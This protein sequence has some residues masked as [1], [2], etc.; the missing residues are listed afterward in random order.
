MS[1]QVNE[2]G[3]NVES[4]AL[5]AEALLREHPDAL[6]CGLS[7]DG[8]IVPVPQSVGLWGQE[9]IEGRAVV[10]AVVAADRKTVI[11][12][13]LRAR[14]EGVAEGKVRLLAKPSRWMTLHFLDLR[15]VH[16]VVLCILLPSDEVAEGEDSQANELP[17]A[18][19]RF[20]TLM[21]DESGVVLDCDEAFM[22]MF[23]YTAE[24]VIGKQVL[25]QLHPDDHARAVEG[26]IAML[27]SRRVQQFRCRRKRKDGSWMWID[28][29]LHNF[30]NQPDRNYVLVEII[31][32]SAEM[33]AQEALQDREELLR[34]LTEAMP[35]GLLQLDTRAKRRLPQPPPAGDPARRA[36]FRIRGCAVDGCSRR[37]EGRRDGALSADA[38][39]HRNRRGH[40]GVRGGIRA[41]AR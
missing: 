27:S 9:A 18:A 23:G 14:T 29:T 20:C 17:P 37:R 15:G 2:Q 12:T 24:E 7:G 4:V 21:E 11:D 41:G 32:V 13:W 25:D 1:Y 35:D 10:D 19:P 16:D 22:Q 34:R 28:T 26:W 3:F 30:L 40:R 36:G 6:V 38:P 5:A 33:V 8:L 39:G 31:D